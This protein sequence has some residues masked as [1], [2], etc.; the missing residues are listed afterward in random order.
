MGFGMERQRC[1]VSRCG[2]DWHRD[3]AAQ[4]AAVSA[5]VPLLRRIFRV[6]GRPEGERGA[7]A[8]RRLACSK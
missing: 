2:G 1:C 8:Q 7:S 5:A 3:G 6:T 4:A